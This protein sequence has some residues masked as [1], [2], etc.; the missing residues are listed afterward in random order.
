MHGTG[1][2]RE[3]QLAC[4]SEFDEFGQRGATRKVDAPHSAAVGN[5][6]LHVTADVRLGRSAEDSYRTAAVESSPVRNFGEPFGE[7]SLGSSE[8]R[9]R[10][11]PDDRTCHSKRAET[12]CSRQRCFCF[13]RKLDRLDWRVF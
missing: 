4:G 10:T 9:A 13:A 1:V 3:E 2:V 12:D 8:S 6:L 11:D 5:A 7:P